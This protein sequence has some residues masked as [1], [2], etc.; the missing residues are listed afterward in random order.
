MTSSRADQAEAAAVGALDWL[1]RTAR[2]AENNGLAWPTRPSEDEL[3]PT[4]YSGASGVVLA[5][6]EAHRHFQDDRYAD[7]ALRGARSIAAAV[8]DG[9][10]TADAAA[11]GW[12]IDSLYF[13]LAGM[14]FALHAVDRELGDPAAAA[15]ARRALGQV[16]ER[17]DGTRWGVHLELLC[18]NAGIALAAL[19]VGDTELALL[20]VEPFT[21]TAE[22]T[23]H[24]VTWE[25]R[26][27]RAAR[28]HHISHGTLGVVS[29]LAAVGRAADRPELLE[30]ACVGAADVIAR[31]EAGPPGFLVPHSDPQQQPELIERY[32]YG[33]CQGPAGD[34][35]A[36][37]QLH[38]ALGDPCWQALA[39]R[40]WHT[41]RRSGLP[42]RLRPGFWD[43]SGRCCGTA[44][45]LAL[46]CDR[47]A[48]G[49][50]GSDFADTLV[51][52]LL[53]R[54]TGDGSGVRWSNAEHRRTPSAL[55]PTP[56]WAMGNAGI[57]RELLRHARL[58]TGRDPGYAVAWPDQPPTTSR[59]ARP[60]PASPASPAAPGG[61]QSPCA[62]RPGGSAPAGATPEPRPAAPRSARW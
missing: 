55:E 36:F 3:D 8:A 6:L 39:D 35:Q 59:A 22:P 53:A 7:A 24:G 13:G 4:L 50:D 23:P 32:N 30:L 49:G 15:A 29:A 38:Q 5:L 42:R 10:L 46:A 11:D 48:E 25:T 60:A 28:Q 31:D 61:G 26:S 54:A 33:W 45:V 19:A 52:D 44:G 9:R 21:R 2:R 1:L 40:C 18:G 58:R 16:P 51:A 57:I 43:N 14:A 62:P 34:A 37:R 47:E 27:G 20:A 17:F 12:P 41:V 56:G